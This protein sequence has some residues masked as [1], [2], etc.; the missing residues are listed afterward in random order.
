MLLV[1]R[2]REAVAFAQPHRADVYAELVVHEVAVAE[3]ELRAAPAAVEH[4]DGAQ[5]E[6]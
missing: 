6:P 3:G 5:L 4:G 2:P 1:D